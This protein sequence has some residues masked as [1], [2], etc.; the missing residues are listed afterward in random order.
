M[1][2][3]DSGKI[4]ILRLADKGQY[5]SHANDVRMRNTGVK[6]ATVMHRNAIIRCCIDD[7]CNIFSIAIAMS[8]YWKV[9]WCPHPKSLQNP[10]IKSNTKP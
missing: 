4:R 9:P 3:R 1:S 6:K 10:R 7:R 2:V 8:D 5:H